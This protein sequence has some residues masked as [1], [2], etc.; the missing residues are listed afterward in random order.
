[1]LKKIIII[2]CLLFFGI[3]ALAVTDEELI[4]EQTIQNRI[5]NIGTKILNSN[6][7]PNRVIFVYD[8]TE[9]KSKLKM[10]TTLSSRQ[11]L[12][13]NNSYKFIENDD[14]LAAFLARGIVL[15]TR[16]FDGICS[17]GLKSVQMKAA[18][19]KYQI[20]ADKIAID[21]MVNAGYHPVA[22]ITYL[23]KTAPQK[24]F[25]RFS[26]QN[27]T[28]KRLAVIYEYIYTKYPY[29]LA[30]NPYFENEHY[31]NFLLTSVN[32]RK[33]LQQKIETG[34]KEKLKYE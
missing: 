9:K 3:P 12:M 16:S 10:D 1:M 33:L 19:K 18:P 27:L 20:V 8:K 15:A 5:D 6:K 22:L 17:G 24:R 31:Q 11:I 34:S 13:Y 23:Q 2:M 14:E 32:N 30:N 21:Y 25:D 4:Q 28:S 7:I 29:Y 26:N